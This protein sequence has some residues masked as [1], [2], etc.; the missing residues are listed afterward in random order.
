MNE[1]RSTSRR[2]VLKGGTIEFNRAGGVSCTVRNLSDKGACLEVE[3][4][5]GLPESFDLM[6]GSDRHM[7]HCKVVWQ[8]VHRIGV[9][10]I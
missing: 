9:E 10:F 1:R 2:R 8:T 5:L 7:H 6:I 4:P 3:S